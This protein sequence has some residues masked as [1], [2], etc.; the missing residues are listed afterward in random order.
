MNKLEPRNGPIGPTFLRLH[1]AEPHPQ[2]AV[3]ALQAVHASNDLYGS[4]VLEAFTAAE[5]FTKPVHPDVCPT[6]I[7]DKLMEFHANLVAHQD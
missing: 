6:P 5:G 7:D 4:D 1:H 2:I 3:L